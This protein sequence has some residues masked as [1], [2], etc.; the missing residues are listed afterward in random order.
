MAKALK[1]HHVTLIVQDL[2]KACEWYETEFE[3]ERL[4]AFKLDFPAQFYKINDEQQLHLSEWPDKPSF[5]GHA[6]FQVDDFNTVFRRMKE[7]GRIDTSPWG[8]VRQLPDGAMQMFVRDPFDNLI[9][10][11]CAPETEIDPAIFEDDQVDA[12]VNIFVSERNDGRGDQ[13][14]DATLYH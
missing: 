6:C 11:S 8:N 12:G 7:Q 9:E 10:I 14:D 5:R 13:A 3:V 2:E 1:L 4:P